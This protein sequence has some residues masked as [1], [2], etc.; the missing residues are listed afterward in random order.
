MRK[1]IVPSDFSDHAFNALKYA[2]QL[3]RHESC[4]IFIIH[5]Y[6]D[7]V[8][9][10]SRE[11]KRSVLEELKQ[12]T[13]EESDSGLSEIRR[14]IPDVSPNPKHEFKTASIFA[15][16]TDAINE[17]VNKEDIDLVVMGT[18]GKSEIER[19]KF[20]SNTLRVMKYVQCPVMAIPTGHNFQV[21]KNILFPTNY[22]I[23]YKR[24]ELQFLCEMAD[25]S[26]ASITMLYIDPVEHLSLRQED[27]MKFLKECLYKPKLHFET[28]PQDDKASVILDHIGKNDMH[29]LVMVNSRHTLAEDL[30]YTSTIDKLCIEL[31]I[32]YLV[33]QNLG[34]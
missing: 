28:G 7:E 29:L 30:L 10:R 21:P 25:S 9:Q 31:R 8:Y 26:R 2:C 12:V 14:S 1:I 6:A 24:R 18:R 3:F 32:P 17:L 4:E 23:P 20:G 33:L 5:A 27:N 16:L 22:L 11:V 34:R 13:H 15:T 19:D